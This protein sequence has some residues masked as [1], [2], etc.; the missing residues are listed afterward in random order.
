MRELDSEQQLNSSTEESNPISAAHEQRL[1]QWISDLLSYG[2]LTASAIVCIGGIWYLIRHGAEPVD[3]H[4]FRGE[5]DIFR[6]PTGIVAAVLAGR[7][8][9]LIQLG[10]LLLI[11]TPIARV[12]LS[13]VTF[14]RWRD[15]TYT[16]ITL[17]VLT[18]L[19]YSFIGAYV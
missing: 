9:G 16:V 8:R 19:I 15:L 17:L 5:P 1:G 3:Y 4:V 18:G 7:A 6:S 13:L 10:L 2:V 14:L 11:A 12:I